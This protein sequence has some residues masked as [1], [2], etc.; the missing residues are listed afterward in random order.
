MSR[1]FRKESIIEASAEEVFEWHRRPEALPDL[2]PPWEPVTLESVKGEPLAVGTE[3][4]IRMP[5]GMRW[6]ARH[7]ALEPGRM[8]RDEQ[9]KGPFRRWVHTHSFEPLGPDRC[10][11]IDSVE[12]QPPLAWISDWYVRR[13]LQK[14]FDY[15]H[16]VTQRAFAPESDRVRSE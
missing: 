9:V 15:R 13:R 4:V 3:V 1:T 11:L 12:Y 2:T 14:M 5:F 8:F 16:A 7:T 10:R 6:H